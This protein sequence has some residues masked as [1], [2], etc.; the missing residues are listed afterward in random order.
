MLVVTTPTGQIGSQVVRRLLAANATVRVIARHPAKLAPEVR[1]KVD[2][3]E[4][5]SDDQAVLLRALAGAQALF[6]VTPPNFAVADEREYLMRFARATSHALVHHGVRRLVVVSALGR[7]RPDLAAGALISASFARDDE[8]AKTGV[9]MRAL[10]CPDFMENTL[11]HVRSIKH[12]GA[13]FNPSRADVKVP[14]VA[15]RDIAS[16]G[17]RLLLDTSWTGQGGVG[18]LGPEDLSFGDRARIISE[19]LGKPV[20]FQSISSE[21]FI[22]ELVKHGAHP[23]HARGLADMYAA[24]DLG[25]DNSEPRTPENTTTTSYRQWCGEVLK[26]AVARA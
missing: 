21:A 24:K 26:P 1:A 22:A 2:V 3:V 20:R 7:R 16:A 13:I 5:S 14:L 10:W 23:E 6:L 12:E 4:G 9:A 8:L 19:V 11:N 17:A 25:L 18:V 15:T